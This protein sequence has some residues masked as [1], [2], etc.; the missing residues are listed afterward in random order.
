MRTGPVSADGGELLRLARE[1]PVARR[2]QRLDW[3][4]AAAQV[5][6][7]SEGTAL[8]M[9]CVAG[10]SSPLLLDFVELTGIEPVTS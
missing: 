9:A 2:Q 10:R 8:P 4:L 1:I 3:R 7:M 5:H 6:E